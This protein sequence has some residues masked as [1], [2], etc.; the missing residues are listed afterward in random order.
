M[1]TSEVQGA[2]TR[3]TWDYQISGNST[4][5]AGRGVNFEELELD[6]ALR[7]FARRAVQRATADQIET[8]H[9][10]AEVAGLRGVWG[11]GPT[12]ESARESLEES[13]LAWVELKLRR[14]EGLPVL[15]TP[16]IELSQLA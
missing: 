2:K 12:P 4:V 13:I 5:T 6:A 7:T 16:N 1:R 14:G 8:D 9:W 11:D 10:F 15:D 3:L